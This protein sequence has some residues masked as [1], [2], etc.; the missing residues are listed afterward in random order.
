MWGGERCSTGSAEVGR[1][2]KKNGGKIERRGEREGWK[3]G[4]G[5]WEMMR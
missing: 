3:K 1:A 5:G 2:G 4:R